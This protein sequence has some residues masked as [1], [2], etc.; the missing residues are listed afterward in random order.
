MQLLQNTLHSA[1]RG[2]PHREWK[3]DCAAKRRSM[4]PS[5]GL[6]R[7]QQAHPTAGNVIGVARHQG[8]RVIAPVTDQLLP[9]LQLPGGD[10]G[11][12]A[13]CV[14]A[15]GGSLCAPRRSRWW[16]SKT[17]TA[18]AGLSWRRTSAS[19]PTS[20]I[21]Q[22]AAD[23]PAQH[24]GALKA[25]GLEVAGH[26]RGKTGGKASKNPRWGRGAEAE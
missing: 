2:S 16:E 7:M 18:V 15:G 14:I 17:A 4:G 6:K 21:D 22:R 20:G 13:W 25:D 1:A 5:G 19:W 11:Q 23:P 26:G 24:P 3:C 9:P 12:N 10:C 8:L